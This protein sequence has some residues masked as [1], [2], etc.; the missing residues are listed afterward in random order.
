MDTMTRD[1]NPCAASAFAIKRLKMVARQIRARGLTDERVLAAME[2]V[3]REEFVPRHLVDDA[4]QDCPLPI[5]FGQTISQPFTVAFMCCALKLA[6]NDHVLEVGTG[7]GYGA[8]V[9]SQLA[10]RVDTVERIPELAAQAERRLQRLGY[11]NVHVHVADG[12]CGLTAYALFDAIIVTAAAPK[13]P[14]PFVE[15]LSDGGRIVIPVGPDRY[16]QSLCCFT[17][18]GDKLDVQDLGEFTFVPLIGDHGHGDSG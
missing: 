11:D 6:P 14:P 16:S 2:C 8:A 3:P 1:Q 5:G 15:Q 9:L 13:L 18:R 4:Y 17:R 7:S 10:A 12:S